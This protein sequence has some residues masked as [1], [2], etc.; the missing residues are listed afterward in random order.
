MICCVR[1][2]EN[3]RFLVTSRISLGDL[4]AAELFLVSG[5]FEQYCEVQ[6]E[7]GNWLQALALAP[8]VSLSYWKQLMERQVEHLRGRKDP[9][10]VRKIGVYPCLAGH[11][12]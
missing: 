2:E 4:Q 11:L 12:W 8:A 1:C 9:K 3:L 5:A 10:A 7:L 6:I